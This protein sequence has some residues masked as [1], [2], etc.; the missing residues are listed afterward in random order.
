MPPNLVVYSCLFFAV[1][2]HLRKPNQLCLP[3]VLATSATIMPPLEKL[4]SNLA[5]CGVDSLEDGDTDCKDGDS[6][7]Q[8]AITDKSVEPQISAGCGW[9]NILGSVVVE[10]K[11][12]IKFPSFLSCEDQSLGASSQ[13]L[14]G[15]GFKSLNIIKIKS[16]KIYA[17][18]FY[19][20]PDGLKVQLGEKYRALLSEEL[21]N[22][23]SI[24]EDLLRHDLEM[25][26]RLVVHYKGLKVG[27]VRSAFDTSL[28]NRLRKIKGVE[29]DEG[30]HLFNSYFSENLS[31]SRGSV[32]DFQRLSGNQLRTEIDGRLI[33]TICS[34]DF[35][36]AL[37]DLYIGDPPVSLKAK[38]EIG[39]K[40][41]QLLRIS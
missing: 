16:I 4:S 13:V 24:F 33:G 11:T 19:I 29:D 34:G 2:R 5:L 21:K 17:F 1:F 12:G 9:M 32:I 22:N 28:K 6:F 8:V 37:F 27:M 18:G 38:Q 14:V 20:K 30:L 25:T 39:E 41:C 10:P 35:C 36:R 15:V 23:F 31:L 3:A 40:V 26:V 7:R